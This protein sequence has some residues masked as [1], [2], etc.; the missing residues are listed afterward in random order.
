MIE[1]LTIRLNEAASRVQS[2]QEDCVRRLEE[3]K[4]ELHVDL[5]EYV[6]MSDADRVF[7]RVVEGRYVKTSDADQAFANRKAQWDKERLTL[8]KERD[9]AIS[10]VDLQESWSTE[11]ADLIQERN[12]AWR[13]VALLAAADSNKEDNVEE[14][15]SPE[16]ILQE[17]EEEVEVSKKKVR[18]DNTQ[19]G[20]FSGPTTDSDQD[21]H[22]VST[23]D[24]MF[25]GYETAEAEGAAALAA[26]A[27]AVKA[28]TEEDS[29][30]NEDG[31]ESGDSETYEGSEESEESDADDDEPKPKLFSAQSAT[32]PSP[33]PFT[34]NPYLNPSA[35]PSHHVVTKVYNANLLPAVS[36]LKNIGAGPGGIA[37][38]AGPPTD[39]RRWTRS[40]V[41]K[42]LNEM[43]V[44]ILKRCKEWRV[45]GFIHM[46]QSD[47]ELV[48][49]FDTLNEA[50]D[51]LVDQQT[52]TEDMLSSTDIFDILFAFKKTEWRNPGGSLLLGVA[53]FLDRVQKSFHLPPNEDCAVFYIPPNGEGTLITG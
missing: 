33:W 34:T 47:R 50:W 43:K 37:F 48:N 4:T 12:D 1:N 8:I 21:D 6:K 40:Q 16:K 35:T 53:A 32:S 24:D 42:E 29:E 23:N 3:Q 39:L 17:D 27:A 28:S 19:E 18:T 5:S 46:N 26:A 51:V 13:Q 15:R 25:P 2:V 45:Y 7:A 44:I 14:N 49:R 10:Q 30:T 22:M 52:L 31:E 36:A 38:G 9:D 41:E 20:G 11:R